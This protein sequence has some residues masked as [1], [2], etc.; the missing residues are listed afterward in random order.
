MMMLKRITLV[1]VL[2]LLVFMPAAS[3][4]AA[5]QVIEQ[6]ARFDKNT[7]RR[8]DRAELVEYFL[9]HDKVITELRKKGMGEPA[10]R[11]E[12]ELRADDALSY[13]CATCD[14]VS[15]ES[16]GDYVRDNLRVTTPRK[17]KIGWR[18]LSF[19]RFATDPADPRQLSPD[20]RPAL[21]SYKRDSQATDK[22]QVNW[23][24][25]VQL[26]RHVF[27]LTAAPV[28]EHFLTVVPAVEADIDGSKAANET[29][30]EFAL[31][32]TYE[33]ERLRGAERV[34]A[35]LTLTFTPKRLTDR[36]FDREGWEFTTEASVSSVPFLRAGYSTPLA[37]GPDG[38]AL[39]FYWK[40]A[41]RLETGKITDAAGNAKL[42]VLAQEGTY[43][44]IV[45]RITASA[46]SE[47]LLTGLSVGLD[48]FYRFHATDESDY[49]YGELR[50]TYDLTSDRSLSF[51][52]VITR[53]HKPPDFVKTD[54]ILV[55]FGFLQ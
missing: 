42:A 30:L 53:G 31:P 34:L 32:I 54:R 50:F 25:G 17:L 3:A 46:R 15:F 7:D 8:L 51:G 36:R 18:G 13:Q 1:S 21:F 22:D 10:L 40:P 19:R 11:T 48:Y 5:D 44:R 2:A 20:K 26:Y 4:D 37:D 9:V 14:S 33:W 43:S 35:G 41:L 45:P 16:A 39:L 52:L 27:D 28:N 38:A 47:R 6:L 12:A 24:G 55:G 29:S 23:L 49:D